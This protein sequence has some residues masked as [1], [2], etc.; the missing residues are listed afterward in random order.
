[1]SLGQEVSFPIRIRRSESKGISLNFNTSS[2]NLIAFKDW[3]N[4]MLSNLDGD[5]AVVENSQIVKVSE[6]QKKG[7]KKNSLQKK[8]GHRFFIKLLRRRLND[9]LIS[10]LGVI[11]DLVYLNGFYWFVSR[12]RW[13][14]K[15]IRIPSSGNTQESQEEEILEIKSGFKN[16]KI[17]IK[18]IKVPLENPLSSQGAGY[19]NHFEMRICAHMGNT[20]SSFIDNGYRAGLDETSHFYYLRGNHQGL[21]Y[22]PVA[23][24]HF[25]VTDFSFKHIKNFFVLKSGQILVFAS[26][27]L[28]LVKFDWKNL[29]EIFVNS[30]FKLS[31][32]ISN[33]SITDNYDLCSKQRILARVFCHN[34]YEK[35]KIIYIE[36]YD[37]KSIKLRLRTNIT[38]VNHSLC[39]KNVEIY[40]VR[41]HDYH[42]DL[43]QLTILFRIVRKDE[44]LM[45]LLG[46]TA[47]L[48]SILTLV[49]ESRSFKVL[50]ISGLATDGKN[51]IVEWPLIYSLQ[52][53]GRS[54]VGIDSE[55]IIQKI[56]F[57]YK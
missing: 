57:G 18:G 9:L 48:Q 15:L 6:K 51:K 28:Y 7:S 38:V 54:L 47:P 35:T 12:Y 25:S 24:K 42:N 49:F 43:L 17:F 37:L 31:Q 53:L 44:K 8:V 39:K 19:E 34:F 41:L 21:S 16:T 50:N 11:T 14:K 3:S 45:A 27:G 29:Q 26:S 46:K 40:D 20:V 2:T 1:M 23:K 52:R 55:G 22:F 4:F 13:F 33:Y 36:F 5:Y 30:E 32:K 56:K 10:F